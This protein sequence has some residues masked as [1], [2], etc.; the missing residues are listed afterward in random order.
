VAS[1]SGP[2]SVQQSAELVFSAPLESSEVRR[3][4]AGIY[5]QASRINQHGQ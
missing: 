1:T 3:R 5:E 2:S 4:F